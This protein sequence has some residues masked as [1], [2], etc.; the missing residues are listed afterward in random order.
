MDEVTQQLDEIADRLIALLG[1]PSIEFE[2]D[3]ASL[4]ARCAVVE[5]VA[6]I[7]GSTQ[8]RLAGEVACRSRRELGD[9]GLSRSQNFA[10]PVKLLAATAGISSRAAKVRLDLGTRLRGA[11]L[12]GGRVG[13]E[14][15][16]SISS[17]MSRGALSAET[18]SV[19]AHEC[20]TL[21]MRGVDASVVTAAEEQLVAAALDPSLMADDIARLAVRVREHLDP[22]GLEPRAEA[23]HEARAF[24]LARCSDGMYR[25]RLA[26]APEAASIWLG[27]IQALISPR[28]TPRFVDH[29]RPAAPAETLE[30]RQAAQSAETED[31]RVSRM[32]TADVRTTAQKMADAATDLIA[33]AAAA[34]DLP[35]LAG[36]T[37][38]VNVHVG[39]AD[40][41]AGRGVGWIDGLDEPLP[42]SAVERLRCHS[43]VTTTVFG[44]GGEI[45][46]HGKARRLFSPAQN[47]ALAARDGG[48]V[49][50][51]C[52]RPPSWCETHHVDEWRS[53]AHPP[54]KT[55]VDNGVLLCRAHHAHL[56]KSSWRLVMR[57]GAPHIIPP[58][59]IDSA[60]KPIPVTRR[61]TLP[62]LPSPHPP[63]PTPGPAPESAA[64]RS[65]IRLRQ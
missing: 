25:G 19:I 9:E 27:A 23:Q 5:R 1:A 42:Q 14:P 20:S 7:V 26:L 28:A 53:P 38:T 40:L 46:H 52:D 59:W 56:H 13:P 35:R 62:P 17:S 55:D 15:F 51:G 16:P 6:R 43:P 22:D 18:A 37:T 2:L 30:T 48:C 12:L 60:Q 36:A 3:D 54:G 57:A 39:L 50:P 61:R 11:A 33:R 31:E 44:D 58:R 34:P 64:A 24:T 10:T 32:L 49:W 8:T 29:E 4:L 47:R 21:S 65:T 63:N 41:E 45:L